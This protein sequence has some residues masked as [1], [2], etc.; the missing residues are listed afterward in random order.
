LPDGA[1][2]RDG[3]TAAHVVS[4]RIRVLAVTAMVTVNTLIYLLINA[5]PTRTP[6]LLP[7]T[8]FDDALGRHAW[9]IWPYWLLLVINPFFA[10]A[11]RE[12]N[13]LLATLRAYVVA[14]GLNIVV[15]LAWP[16]RIARDALPQH[17]DGLTQ[18][19]WNLPYAL[20]E[21]NTCFPSG[22]ITIPCVVMAGFAT[23]YPG[24]R[25]WIWVV[26]LLFP[27]IV[28]TGQHYAIDLFAGMLTAVA[29]IALAG[30]PLL[31]RSR[32]LAIA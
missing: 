19:A 1:A 18:G 8:W 22:H 31:M 12:R 15:W 16:T 10:V 2:R 21:P 28:T 3:S 4:F 24:A 26:A 9:T 25:R 5:N 27:T 13:V 11:I 30:R 23:Q 29:G 17:L 14:I 6:A 7:M 32:R 20:D